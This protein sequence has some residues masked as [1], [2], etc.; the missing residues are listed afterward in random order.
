MSQ[1]KKKIAINSIYFFVRHFS[2]GQSILVLAMMT[3]SIMKVIFHNLFPGKHWGFSSLRNTGTIPQ[4]LMKI[5][6]L[7]HYQHRGNQE[8]LEKKAS[9]PQYGGAD[10]PYFPIFLKGS[11]KVKFLLHFPYSGSKLHGLSEL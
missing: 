6:K 9:A 3:F 2:Y 7:L 4:H 5:S 10:F 8:E 1:R 11:L